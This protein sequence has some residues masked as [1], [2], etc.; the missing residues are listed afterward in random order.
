MESVD[1]LIIGGGIASMFLVDYLCSRGDTSLILLEKNH[2]DIDNIF[3]NIRESDKYILDFYQRITGDNL[4][5]DKSSKNLKGSIEGFTKI[6]KGE[7]SISLLNNT[8][9]NVV[10]NHR[11]V[12]PNWKK[13]NRMWKNRYGKYVRYNSEVVKL[14]EKSAIT[15]YGR[16]YGAKNIIIDVPLHALRLLVDNPIYR[17]FDSQP[18]A[19]LYI[20]L[21]NE[22]PIKHNIKYIIPSPLQSIVNISKHTYLLQA[23]GLDSYFLRNIN[24]A[25]LS[26]ILGLMFDNNVKIKYMKTIVLKDGICNRKPCK[27]TNMDD[28]CNP[29]PN[30]FVIGNVVSKP[31]GCVE[32]LV[33]TTLDIIHR[34]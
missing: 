34:V 16:L 11:I 19:Y 33:D 7:S 4:L 1:R 31:N 9:H 32:S 14:T 3:G 26:S 2:S 22:L 17:S 23:D 6:V 29:S 25:Y 15:K 10:K 24:K 27:Y 20:Y 12:F 13:L 28:I 18:I 5:N 8:P 30:I 21:Y